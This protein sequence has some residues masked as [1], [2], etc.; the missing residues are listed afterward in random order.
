MRSAPFAAAVG[1]AA[2]VVAAIATVAIAASSGAFDGSTTVV[3]SSLPTVS[4][5]PVTVG[6]ST[7]GIDP[8]SIY[9]SRIDGV[10]TIASVFPDSEAGGSGFVVSNDGL[11]LTNAH[12]VT[13]SA[14]PG[15]QPKDVKPAEH[16]YVRFSDDD[17]VDATIV[18]YDLFADVA[19]L[20][21]T[22]PNVKLV[23]VPLGNSSKVKVGEPVAAIGSPFLEAGSLSV[24]V[25]SAINRSLASGTAFQIPG[26]IQT[27]AAINHGNSGGP[28]F[29]A[30]GEVIGINAQ[31]Q[32]T[33]GGGEGVGFA[34][35]ID[36]AERA[37]KQLV[38][39]GHVAYGWLGV[40]LG[41]ITPAVADQF[42][43]SVTQGALIE[44]ITPGGPAQ[45][46]GLVVGDKV[47]HFQDSSLRPSGD[48]IV[49]VDGV[50]VISS[51]QF[52]RLVATRDPGEVLHLKVARDGHTR[53]VDV[54][55]GTR[56]L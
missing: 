21:V 5:Q 38:E 2:G 55:L 10:V 25:V 13:N 53:M 50:A 22:D 4:P 54:T 36:L 12:V 19:V 28:L 56:P 43:L 44:E 11:I 14:D 23:P 8:G 39:T 49:S 27:D 45:Q 24:G 30:A 48:V 37:M 7:G 15:V 32:S 52:V 17:Q 16:V 31:I 46:A 51:D 33:S 42:N 40:R 6:T 26:A 29:N 1:F 47:E 34:V 3:Q 41:T 20:R 18:G 9:R 35:P